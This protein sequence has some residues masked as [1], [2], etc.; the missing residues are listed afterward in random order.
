MSD[1]GYVIQNME[2]KKFLKHNGADQGSD[3]QYD[4]VN[5]IDKAKSFS[6]FEHVCY[7]AFWYA[8]S[9]KNWRII[10]KVT[11]HSFI[12]DRGRRFKREGDK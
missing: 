8:D 11:K 12:H 9:S 10:D 2:S 6:T 1:T 4:E 3:D 5:K 7:A